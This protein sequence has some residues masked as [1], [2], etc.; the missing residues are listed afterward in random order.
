MMSQGARY[1]RLLKLVR[2]KQPKCIVEIGTHSGQR[3]INMLSLV[4]T[5]RYYGFDLFEDATP[6]TD[7]AEFNNKKRYTMITVWDRLSVWDVHL[8]KGNTRNTL[9]L[10]APDR[11]V[12][13]VWLDGGHSVET[14][15]SDWENIK[16]HLAPD[17]VVLFDDYYTR[18]PFDTTKIG[19]NAVVAELKHEILPESDPV[20]GGGNVQ[21]ARV[22]P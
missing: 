18:V 17:A 16:K 14:I 3:A 12:D 8:T 6:E 10:F 5:A 9:P 4:P 13:F 15:R 20:V 19:C 22:Y 7:A 21:I 2:E 1:Q 11:P